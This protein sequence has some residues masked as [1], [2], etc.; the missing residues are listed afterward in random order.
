MFL[1]ANTFFMILE[2]GTKAG[3]SHTK[4][5]IIYESMTWDR[6]NLTSFPPTVGWGDGQGNG[7]QLPLGG[8]SPAMYLGDLEIVVDNIDG[9]EFTVSVQTEAEL[10]G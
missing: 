5:F 9:P 2:T 8:P 10:N 1:Q 7:Y 6:S 3:I 4:I